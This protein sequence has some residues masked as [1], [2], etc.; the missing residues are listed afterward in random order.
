MS[1]LEGF[2]TSQMEDEQKG[3][4]GILTIDLLSWPSTFVDF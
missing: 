2:V 3:I 4:I 1:G